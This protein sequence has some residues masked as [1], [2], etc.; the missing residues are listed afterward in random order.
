MTTGQLAIEILMF[1][2]SL[3]LGLYLINRNKQ[4]G[5]LRLVG[6]GLVAYAIGLILDILAQYAQT[7]ILAETLV[8]WQRPFLFLPAILWGAVLFLLTRSEISLKERWQRHPKPIVL[9]FT[10]SIFFALGLSFIFFP[11][12][13]L[14]RAVVLPSLGLDLLGLG[15]AVAFL[16][17]FDEGEALLPHFW[18]SFGYSFIIALL[19][20]GQVAL[21]MAWSTGFT[22]PLLVLLLSTITVAIVVQTF[23]SSLQT[24]LDQLVFLNA[25]Q[26]QKTRAQLRAAADV[27]PRVNQG[28]DLQTIEPKEFVRFTRRALSHMGDL[29]KL[30]ANPLTQLPLVEKRLSE[31]Q[32]EADTLTRAAELKRVLTESIERLKPLDKGDFGTSDEWRYYNALYFPYVAGLRPYSR[33]I[34]YQYD[35]LET[36]GQQALD[37]FRIQVPERTLYN[38]QNAAAKLIA[39]DLKERAFCSSS[40]NRESHS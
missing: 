30:A 8:R 39:Q 37:W 35:D 1:A 23:S 33:R 25:P 4:D 29:P 3:W 14:P 34:T 40:N 19:F 32:V 12:D 27:A 28:I 7:A 9:V 24:V 2:F 21:V 13:W 18:R 17:A 15:V 38:W 11:L 36:T 5:R 20:G 6:S 22:F 31:R 10:T 26:V 16:D